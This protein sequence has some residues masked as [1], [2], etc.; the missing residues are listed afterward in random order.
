MAYNICAGRVYGSLLASKFPVR[1]PEIMV[2]LPPGRMINARA[3]VRLPVAAAGAVGSLDTFRQGTAGG[4]TGVEPVHID[5][6]G[7]C[8]RAAYVA[9]RCANC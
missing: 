3:Q 6:V 5:L 2:C 9:R 1:R 8:S 4:A 7:L